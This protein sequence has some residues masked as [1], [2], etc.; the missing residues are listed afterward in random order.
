MF[1]EQN[2]MY[3][4]KCNVNKSFLKIKHV[5]NDI[6]YLFRFLDLYQNQLFI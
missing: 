1:L 4:R 6:E 5:V 3:L 2:Q